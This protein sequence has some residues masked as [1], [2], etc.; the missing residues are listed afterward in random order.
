MNF[1]IGDKV[2]VRKHTSYDVPY[3]ISTVE[4]VT[5]T[6]VTVDGKRYLV[7]NGDMVGGGRYDPSIRFD[8]TVADAEKSNADWAAE[9]EL[10]KKHSLICRAV[11][12]DKFKYKRELVEKVYDL[13]FTAGIFDAE[14]GDN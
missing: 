4:K 5:A 2:V 11:N 12:G 9:R 10:A 14:K 3:I 13:M 8:V 1:K 7:R 6:Q